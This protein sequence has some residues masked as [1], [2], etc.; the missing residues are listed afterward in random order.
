MAFRKLSNIRE[1]ILEKAVEIG[2]NE[3]IEAITA[4]KVASATDISTHTIYT[5]FLSM[6]DLIDEAA[7]RYEKKELNL[8]I[9]YLKESK[10]KEEAF[11]KTL[12]SLM[13][14]KNGT[15]FYSAY[16]SSNLQEYYNRQKTKTQKYIECSKLLFGE[17]KGVSDEIYLF[18]WNH[19]IICLFTYSSALIREKVVDTLENR[20]TIINII[21][22]GTTHILP[23]Q[24]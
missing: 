17:F 8:L 9:S 6:G 14:Q 12:D 2:A 7:V 16:R 18:L 1:S 10:D 22:N 19:A 23:N 4:R 5:N 20:K 21:F 24:K 15:L 3:G 13:E 11:L